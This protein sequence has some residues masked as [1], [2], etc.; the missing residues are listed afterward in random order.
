[1]NNPNPSL[2]LAALLPCFA[3]LAVLGAGA[4]FAAD[5]SFT[6]SADNFRITLP[7]GWTRIASANP[8]VKFGAQNTDNTSRIVVMVNPQTAPRIT[9][10]FIAGMKKGMERSGSVIESDRTIE[11]Q[12]LP[13][14]E[15]TGKTGPAFGSSPMIVR[16]ILSDKQSYQVI[17]VARN[18]PDTEITQVIESFQLLD[19]PNM[20]QARSAAYEMG[21]RIGALAVAFLIPAVVLLGIVAIILVFVLR[22]KRQ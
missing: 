12:G 13:A 7:T 22:K 19:V 10:E 18:I 16:C 15:V 1:M 8:M 6:N 9:P 17:G 2:R 4:T 20:K 14:V 5:R 11:V 21:R 3:L